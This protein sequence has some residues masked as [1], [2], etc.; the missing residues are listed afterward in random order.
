MVGIP[1]CTGGLSSSLIGPESAEKTHGFGGKTATSVTKNLS[2]GMSCLKIGSPKIEA[3]KLLY[4]EAP[5]EVQESSV[6]S[7]AMSVLPVSG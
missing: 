4:E 3:C 2:H 5:E 1:G 6:A 7:K